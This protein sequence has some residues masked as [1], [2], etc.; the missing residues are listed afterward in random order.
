[1]VNK[2]VENRDFAGCNANVKCLVD[3]F[4]FVDNTLLVGDDS[5]NHLW[6]MKAVLKGLNL[7]SGLESTI[8]KVS[9][10]VLM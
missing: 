10:L 3:V 4:Q 5:W 9:L 8:T 7:F 6:E 1:M 2:V